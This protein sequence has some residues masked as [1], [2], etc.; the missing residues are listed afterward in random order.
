M[1]GKT[2]GQ[3]ICKK[4]GVVNLIFGILLLIV[5][6]NLW[7]NSPVWWNAWTLVG[8]YLGLWGLFA[9]TGKPH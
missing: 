9:A 3:S 1:D 8:L 7:K 6:L 2:C 4:C 5:G